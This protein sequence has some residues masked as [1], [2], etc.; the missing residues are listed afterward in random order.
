MAKRRSQSNANDTAGSEAAPKSKAP[1]PPAT[2][3]RSM[4]TASGPTESMATAPAP[5]DEDI[6]HR[7]YLRY[8][9]RGQND[10]GE[11][12]D[13]LYAERELKKN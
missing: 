5:T 2:P 8:L 1:R 12:D 6:R 11:F 13:W 9:E 4:A 10:G 7:A 3:R